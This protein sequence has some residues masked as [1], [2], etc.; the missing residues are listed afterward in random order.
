[1]KELQIGSCVSRISRNGIPH[2][3]FVITEPK[4]DP[5]GAVAVNITDYNHCVDKTVVLT[6]GHPSI[7]KRS[8]VNYRAAIYL[9]VRKIEKEINDGEKQT[10]LHHKEPVCNEALLKILQDGLLNSVHTP[11]RIKQFCAQE[12]VK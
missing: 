4:G 9:D 11:E 1:M 5:L 3:Y 7:T 12:F 2:Y 10:M 8:V 6:D